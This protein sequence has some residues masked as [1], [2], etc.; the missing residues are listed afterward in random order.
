MGGP[1]VGGVDAGHHE[2]GNGGQTSLR[3]R[4]SGLL[5]LGDDRESLSTDFGVDAAAQD[6]ENPAGIPR[7]VSRDERPV[8]PE[9][10]CPFKGSLARGDVIEIVRHERDTHSAIEDDQCPFTGEGFLL[11]QADAGDALRHRIN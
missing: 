6:V 11:A 1:V 9:Q 4:G 10:S 2:F 8:G 3:S 5:C 7:G